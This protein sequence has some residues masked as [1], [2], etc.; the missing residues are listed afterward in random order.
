MTNQEIFNNA[1]K[2]ADLEA[3]QETLNNYNN[4]LV[5]EK[6]VIENILLNLGI[7]DKPISL[8]LKE[9]KE[10][11]EKAQEIVEN[12]INQALEDNKS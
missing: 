10:Y 8:K 6:V 9:V 4:G 7:I 11:E 2:H 1:L 3:I 5:S 12:Q